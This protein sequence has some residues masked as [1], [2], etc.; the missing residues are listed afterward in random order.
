MKLQVKPSDP[1]ILDRWVDIAYLALYLIYAAWAIFSVVIGLPTVMT[2]ASDAYQIAWS[3][4]IGILCLVAAGSAALTFFYVPHMRQITKKR[5]E[6]AS[7]FTLW[8]FIIVYPVLLVVRAIDGEL[9][10]T[11]P[12]A[13]L[14]ISYLIFPTLRLWI[15][16][17][18]IQTLKP[19]KPQKKVTPDAT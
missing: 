3:G 17:N 12:A 9:S 7:V 19:P 18:R 5:V 4:T 13:V 14:A 1:L 16:H 11:G 8:F 15:L 2:L 10:V 6:F